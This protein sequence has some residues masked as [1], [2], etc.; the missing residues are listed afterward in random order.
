MI[1]FAHNAASYLA[2]EDFLASIDANR[3][4]GIIAGVGD[5][6]DQDIMECGIISA[7]MFDHII[8]RQEKHLRGRTEQEMVNLLVTGMQSINPEIS[9]EVIPKEI[10]AIEHAMSIAQ[11]DDF[12]IA[13]SDVV[14]NA[15][16]I[17][18]QH[19]DLENKL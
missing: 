5:R 4:I 13:L 10:K 15:I 12:I 9:Y 8:I 18:Q 11:K 14:S 3:K 17:V 7:R 19:L 16:A 1:D 2:I 6:R